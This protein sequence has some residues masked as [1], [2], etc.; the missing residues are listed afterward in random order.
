ML[1]VGIAI[2]A[3]G[4]LLVVL[5]GLGVRWLLRR[6]RARRRPARPSGVPRFPVVL[7]HGMCGFD[8]L[9]VFG[10]R[11]AYFLGIGQHLADLGVKVHRA[12]LPPLA[13]VPDR[14]A[15]LVRFVRDLG[16]ERVNLIAH[17]MGGL[18]ARYAISR[19]GAADQIA[20]LVT[21]GTPHH[22]TPLADVVQLQPVRAAR[23]L[24]KRLGLASECLDW[25]TPAR[26]AAFNR[27]IADHPEVN[28]ASV[29]CRAGERF[30][31]R[32]PLLLAPHAFVRWRAGP[33]DGLVPAE[34]QRWGEILSE[35]RADHWA[36]IG[37][38]T[39]HDARPVYTEIVAHLARAG[40]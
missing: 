28:Y 26:M 13:S 32:N 2:V 9:S 11:P 5:L 37:W 10:W 38:F 23:A 34:S 18:D 30:L 25:L 33:N 14:A 29:V 1:A 39:V 36:Q 35:V 21:I 40:L 24:V 12:Q 7:V 17:S 4:V 3:A 27:E 16:A 31:G 22:G 15:A 6:A 19:L 20:S 8:E